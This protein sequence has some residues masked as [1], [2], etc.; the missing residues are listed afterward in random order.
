MLARGAGLSAVSERRIYRRLRLPQDIC[1][2]SAQEAPQNIPQDNAQYQPAQQEVP[3]N[4]PQDN[5]QY[6]PAQQDAPQNIPRK[7]QKFRPYANMSLIKTG[8]I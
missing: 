7:I 3:Q 6:Q 5:A 8:T 4:I 1:T 2:I